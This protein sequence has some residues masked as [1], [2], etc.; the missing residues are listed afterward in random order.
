MDAKPGLDDL[1]A[2]LRADVSSGAA[3]LVRKAAEAMRTAAAALPAGSRE[4]LVAALADVARAVVRAQ[5]AMAP[6]VALARA[7]LGAV[8]SA[9]DLDG[10]RSAAAR[11]AADFGRD[12]ERRRDR[13]ASH[14]A[15]LLLDGGPVMT[16]SSSS[17]IRAALV[18]RKAPEG[19]RVVCLEGRPLLEGRALAADL[20]RAG[21]PVT[22]GVDAAAASLARDCRRV[23]SGADS[24]GDL[25]VVNK[26]GTMA[27]AEAARRF[28]VPFH[29]IAD[30]TKILPPGFVQHLADDRPAEEV[31]RAPEG[32]WVWN[33][34]FEAVP[35]ELVT[36]VVTEA[37]AF[38]PEEL[39]TRR[40]NVQFPAALR[41]W[42]ES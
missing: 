38:T 32:V 24:I 22:L 6:M 12:I 2:T 9:D 3:Q 7:V 4:E 5:P 35:L 10:A 29:V 27:A 18:G 40:R 36:S 16:V 42:T 19:V 28:G 11:A 17:T 34:Y 31:W 14:A 41:S 25:G 23:L 1:L 39:E 13:A 20:A 37:G 8:E 15:E 21:V 33:R 30:E 26:I